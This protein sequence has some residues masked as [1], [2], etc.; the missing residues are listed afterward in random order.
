[1]N[2][3]DVTGGIV[4]YNNESTIRQCIQSVLEHTKDIFF[5]LYIYDNCST[6]DT[7]RIILEEFPQVKLIEGEEN[8][9]FGRG[10]NQIVKRVKSDYH[11]IINPDIY[12]DGPVICDMAQY[13]SEHE[14]VVQLTPEIRNMD[15]TIQHLPKLDPNFKFVI[16]S[17]FPMFKHYRTVYTMADV[18]MEEP[19][20]VLSA[21]GCFS[22]VRTE[23]FKK[24]RGY[25]KRFFLYFEDADLSRR[26]RVEGKIIYHPGMHASHAWKR[27][28]TGSLKGIMRFMKSMWKYHRKWR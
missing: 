17:K 8:L 13:M 18:V 2:K 9:G 26:L 14:D 24:I 4:T 15:G 5:Q 12:L 10:H 3:I 16:L 23:V 22:M 25:D 19:T 28:N 11:V 1:M 21:T 6:D 7:V 20:E 27:D